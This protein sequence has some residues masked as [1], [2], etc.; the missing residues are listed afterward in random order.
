MNLPFSLSDHHNIIGAATR[1]HA[2]L[3]ERKQI[4]Y[5]SFKNFDDD[6]YLL[7]LSSAPFHVSQLF[8]DVDDRAW[9]V[10]KLINNII[11]KHAPLKTK[12]VSSKQAPFM[13]S[14]LRKA[15]YQRNMA[16]N[17]FRKFGNSYW[18]EYRKHRNYVASLRNKSMARYFNERCSQTNK[19]HFWSTI[20]PFLSNKTSKHSSDIILQEG[21]RLIV[22]KAEIP[23]T[24]NAYYANVA[25][26]FGFN[27][28]AH[29]V[30]DC[31][32]KYRSHSS[33]NLILANH[34]PVP[35][36]FQC[37]TVGDID[38]RLM[39]INTKKATGYDNIPGKLLRLGR[40]YLKDPLTKLI[41]DCIRES[42]FPESLKCAELSPLFKKDDNMVKE[43]YRPVS[44]LTGISK[45]YESVLNDQMTDYF[46]YIFF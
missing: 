35:F 27:D 29:S 1:R 24:F 7:D 12:F 18:E 40:G 2:P 28:S 25:S 30:D 16:R 14:K 11:D 26:Q 22:D 4:H 42:R 3:S 43:N 5:R 6:A 33:I 15:M 46:N 45:L 41:N 39:S 17:R 8:D 9:Y 37:A 21:D 19:K 44:V 38:K 13:N 36:D 20:S 31:I 23:D 32:D 10:S 34:A